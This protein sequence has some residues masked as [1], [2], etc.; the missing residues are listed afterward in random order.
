MF[1]K[2]CLLALMIAINVSVEIDLPNGN[3][4]IFFIWKKSNEK[5]KI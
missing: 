3:S 4:S 1:E 5:D 2:N